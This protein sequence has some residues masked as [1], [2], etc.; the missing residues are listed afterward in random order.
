MHTN[1]THIAGDL[2]FLL[3]KIY[4][5]V[6]ARRMEWHLSTMNLITK[7]IFIWFVGGIPQVR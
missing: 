5:C 2:L 4:V 7:R 1:S 3:V 6:A